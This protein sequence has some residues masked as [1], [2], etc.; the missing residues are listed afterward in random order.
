MYL[1][2][3]DGKVVFGTVMIDKLAKEL[4]SVAGK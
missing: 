2:D 4:A 1:I 3:P